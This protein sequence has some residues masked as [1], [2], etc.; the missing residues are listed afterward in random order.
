[1]ENPTRQPKTPR[2]RRAAWIKP[3]SYRRRIGF[4][5][6]IH[7]REP[8]YKR[9]KVKG[10]WLLYRTA[11]S[12]AVQAREKRRTK[13][14]TLPGWTRC[15]AY[16]DSLRRDYDLASAD[17]LFRFNR[18]KDVVYRGS[19]PFHNL[20][21]DHPIKS[22]VHGEFDTGRVWY[23]AKHDT[24][25]ETYLYVRTFK[26]AY[27]FNSLGLGAEEKLKWE[28]AILGEYEGKEYMAVER[29]VGW[30]VFASTERMGA[31]VHQG[32]S[33]KRRDT[34]EK[35]WATVWNRGLKRPRILKTRSGEERE[36]TRGVRRVITPWEA[37][38]AIKA[39]GGGKQIGL[40]IRKGETIQDAFRRL[41]S[42]DKRYYRRSLSRAIELLED[43]WKKD[44]RK[45]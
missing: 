16:E 11:K 6:K 5:K 24:Q 19:G 14:I 15:R 27:G 17:P 37:R 32:G 20:V 43:Q 42:R 38:K 29:F 1:M 26:S 36:Q 45:P 9:I 22:D 3:Y 4:V 10:H 33:F 25:N 13:Q 8:V 35:A 28:A 40:T 31:N 2:G 41:S 30:T 12:P 7:G 18:R 39:L 34:K 21:W 23:I 44:R